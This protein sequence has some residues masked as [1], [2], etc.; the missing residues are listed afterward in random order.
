METGSG[1]ATL[2]SVGWRFLPMQTNDTVLGVVGIRS[3]DAAS[4]PEPALQAASTLVGQATIA[5]DRLRL[6]RWRSA[7]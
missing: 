6:S 7:G 5:L 3:G 1:T 4:L 2:P